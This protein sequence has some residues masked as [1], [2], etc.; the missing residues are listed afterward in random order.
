MDANEGASRGEQ[1]G[2]APGA[3]GRLPGIGHAK[4][5]AGGAVFLLLTVG[6]FWYQL[7]RIP[8]GGAGPTWAGL[9]PAY[10]AL[11]LLLL[12]VETL[13][14]AARIWLLCRVLQPGVGFWACVKAEWANAAVSLLTPSQSGGGPG[15]IYMLG[16]AGARVGTA[17]T[18]SLLSFVGTMVGLLAMGVYSL[19]V[20]G[21]GASGPLFAGAV[22]SLT[23][24]AT[25]MLLAAAW[26]DGLRQGL[27]GLSRT[28]CR[29][30]GR[31]RAVQDWWPPRE[32]RGGPPVDRMDRWTARL[33]DLAYVYADD[34]RRFLRHG[35]GVF[36]AVSLLSLAFLLARAL[37]PYLCLRFLG[38]KT[39][40]FAHVLNAQIALIFLVFFAP[41]PGG[42][43]IAEGA[44]LAV[45]AGVIPVGFAPYYNL[46]WRAATAYLAALAGLA[47]L[48]H[49]LVADGRATLRRRVEPAT[50][51]HSPTREEATR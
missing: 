22:W 50:V 21:V 7:S 20:S 3:G 34:V 46:L 36:A 44:S 25:V 29:L 16:R 9:R 48:T 6:I 19:L 26:P 8:G 33:V 31:S 24:I 23:A 15:Q 39:P 28:A 17:L 41:T 13:A 47:C 12:P 43:G 5:V 4:L 37:M 10:L 40:A 38:I 49:A 18:I 1:E 14:S 35:K 2:R 11:I 45:M 27:A 32:G 42:A 30:A 51:P